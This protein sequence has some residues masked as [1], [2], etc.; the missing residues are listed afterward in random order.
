MFDV[1]ILLVAFN[2][3]EE[4][5][6]TLSAILAIQPKYLY[7]F[8][9]GPRVSHKQDPKLIGTVREYIK[10]NVPAYCSLN[11]I[12]SPVN[13]G[14]DLAVVTGLNAVFENHEKAII[15]EDD[16]LATK[17]FFYFCDVLLTRYQLDGRVGMITGTNHVSPQTD[18]IDYF[19]SR[20]FA[21]WGW[22]TWKRAWQYQDISMSWREK[23]DEK[24]II[25]NI[26]YGFWSKLHYQICLRLIDDEKVEAWDWQWYFSLASQNMLC[27]FPNNNLVHNIGFNDLATHTFWYKRKYKVDINANYLNN[28]M[29]LDD[30]K[31][32]VPNYEFDK[33]FVI[34]KHFPTL[35]KYILPKKL[36][37]LVKRKFG[38]YVKS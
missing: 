28:K 16:C 8:S 2:R 7:V 17:S 29:K 5:K 10:D 34:Q 35:F 1:P 23:E 38:H 22:A 13:V 3:L 19:F 12:E 25:D 36:K 4:V 27:I 9:D 20:N 32:V 24:N 21:C 6:A 33:K 14:C 18:H 37:S 31:Y 11:M 26:G 30:K 15:L